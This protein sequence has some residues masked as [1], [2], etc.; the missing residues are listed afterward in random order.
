MALHEVF[1]K[2]TGRL[3]RGILGGTGVC[4]CGRGQVLL[5]ER[6]GSASRCNPP[7]P[8][9]GFSR[10]L[11]LW[12]VICISCCWG[13]SCFAQAHGGAKGSHPAGDLPRAT[14]VTIMAFAITA[15][16]WRPAE[17]LPHHRGPTAPW[18]QVASAWP[19][20]RS[21]AAR[22]GTPLP[23]ADVWAFC[24]SS[25]FST[26]DPPIRAHQQVSS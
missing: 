4:Y 6:W 22:V 19:A 21:R 10:V 9:P 8:G 14:N 13:G 25:P 24:V 3:E 12:G 26:P 15:V 20:C 18:Q 2:V 7:L 17:L 23:G 5:A 11:L 16:T 1:G